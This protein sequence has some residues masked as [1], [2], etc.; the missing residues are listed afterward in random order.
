MEYE[1]KIIER[2]IQDIASKHCESILLVIYEEDK[3]SQGEIAKKLN[4]LPSGLSVVLKKMETS[5]I[6]LVNVSQ[7]GKFRRYSLPDYMRTYLSDVKVNKAN[8]QKEKEES[9]FLLLQR[10]VEYAGHDWKEEMNRL[11]LTEEL[12]QSNLKIN[13][14]YAFME[15]MK[16]KSLKLDSN[17]VNEIKKFID[18]E[19]LIYLIDKYI[20]A[21][22]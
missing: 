4:L 7:N 19:V 22:L 15:E 5:D 9:L 13:A 21:E 18:N 12:E 17:C 14:F 2:Q 1:R 20:E 8:D 10:F 11:L 3:I 6:P 16:K